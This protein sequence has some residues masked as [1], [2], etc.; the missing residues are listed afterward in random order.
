MWCFSSAPLPVHQK[1]GS[2]EEISLS[3]ADRGY[4]LEA[5]R[6]VGE[7]Q[8]AKLADDPSVQH[9]FLGTAAEA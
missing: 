7:G 5:G 4:L 9:A 3:I 2:I 1:I 8:A 6:M